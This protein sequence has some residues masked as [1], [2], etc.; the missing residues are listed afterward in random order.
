MKAF[1]HVKGNSAI[2]IH[3]YGQEFNAIIRFT[4]R[5]LFISE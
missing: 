1:V 2:L 5:V 4:V 3:N